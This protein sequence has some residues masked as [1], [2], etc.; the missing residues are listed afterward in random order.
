MTPPG[1]KSSTVHAPLQEKKASPL[2]KKLRSMGYKY[3]SDFSSGSSWVQE[4]F[5]VLFEHCPWT[6]DS[7]HIPACSHWFTPEHQ[8]PQ[9]AWGSDAEIGTGSVPSSPPKHR[10]GTHFKPSQKPELKTRADF[11]AWCVPLSRGKA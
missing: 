4:I 11:V 3:L 9:E 10:A 8:T 1:R 5:L 6:C 7:S 2:Q